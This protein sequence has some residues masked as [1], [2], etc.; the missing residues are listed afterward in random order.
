ML[1]NNLNSHGHR[2]HKWDDQKTNCM[3]NQKKFLN[4]K[5]LICVENRGQVAQLEILIL[6]LKL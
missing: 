5:Y 2:H 6:Q 4:E 1:D 3:I